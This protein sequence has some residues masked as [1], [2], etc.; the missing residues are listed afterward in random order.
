M[1][2]GSFENWAG[3]ITDIGPLYPFVGTEMLW[4]ILGLVFWIWWHVVQ[5]K[6][7]NREYE[8]AIKRFGGTESLKGIVDRESPEDP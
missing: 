4:F 6:R 1:S 7:E 8:E 2:T 3:T 5:T